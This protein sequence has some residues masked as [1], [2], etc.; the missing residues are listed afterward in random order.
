MTK[1]FITF[2]QLIP[3]FRLTLKGQH[4]IE[5][6]RM[7]SL[8]LDVLKSAFNKTKEDLADFIQTFWPIKTGALVANAVMYLWRNAWYSLSETAVATIG[9]DLHYLQ[10]LQTM[11]QRFGSV[12]WTNPQTHLIEDDILGHTFDYLAKQ[13]LI[14]LHKFLSS[15]GLEWLFGRGRPPTKILLEYDETTKGRKAW[16]RTVYY[17]GHVKPLE[18]LV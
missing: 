15:W 2:G 14:N 12:N 16:E 3:L 11:K 18:V 7:Q 1:S 17:Y 4:W 6:N 13:L 8:V 5:R 9:S 10:Y